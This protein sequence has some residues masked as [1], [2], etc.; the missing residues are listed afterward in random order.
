[1]QKQIAIVGY[2]FRLPG[3]DRAAFWGDLAAARDLVTE[4]PASRWAKEAYYHPRKSEPG[5]SYTFAAGTLG[6]VTGFDAAFFGISPR[7]AEQMDPQQRLLLELAWEAFEHAGIK[8]SSV[9]GSRGAVYIG[10]SGSDYSYRR[11]DDPASFDASTMTG[12]TASIAAN[13]LSYW[14][15][16]RGPS[17]AV[18]TAC[19]SAMVAFHQACQ[20]LRV[21][22]SELAVAGGVSLHLHPMAFIGFSKAS[23]LSPGGRCKVFDAAGDGYVRSEG[24]GIFLLKTLDAALADGDRV[25]AVVAGSGVNCDGKT[26]GLTVPSW[27]RQ[28]ELLREVYAEAGIRPGD[29]DYLEAHGT[30]TAVGDPIETRALGAALGEARPA[31][32]PLLIG[33]VKSNVGH[34]E[35]ASA[36]AGLVK[37]LACLQQRAVPPTVHLK[38]LNPNIKQ[39]AWNLRVVTKTTPLDSAKPLVIGVNS[40]GFGGANAHVILQSAERLQPEPARPETPVAAP[41]VPLLLSGRG[42]PALRAAA[43]QYA[44]L[45]QGASDDQYYDIAF[46]AYAH[47]EL[48]EQ[49]AVVFGLEREAAAAALERFAGGERSPDLFEGEALASASRAVFVYSGNGSQWAGMGRTLLAE[50][51]EFAAVLAGLDALFA[52]HGQ[53]ALLEQLQRDDLAEALAATEVAQPLLFAIQVGVTELLRQLGLAPAAVV[54]HSVGEVAAAWACGALTLDQAVQVILE[55][56]AQQGRTR[57]EGG[58]LAVGLGEA[59]LRELLAALPEAG[60]LTIAGVNSPRGVTVAGAAS[61][62]DRLESL[63]NEREVFFRRLALDYAFH[64]AAMDPL[65]VPLE[66]ALSGLRPEAGRLPF[67]STVTGGRLGGERLD[68]HYWWR[69]IREPVQF[70]GAVDALVRD[71][72]NVLVEVGPHAVL[73]NYVNEGLRNAGVSGRVIPTLARDDDALR[74]V[75]EAFCQALLAG[76][77]VDLARLFPVR[78]RLVELPAYPWQREPFWLAATA[79]G[80]DLINRRKQHPLL[81]YR[82]RENAA[83][84]ENHIDAALYP[85][86]GDHAVGDTVVFPAAGYAELALAAAAAWRPADSC[87]LEELE[88]RAPLLLE[89]DASKTVRFSIDESDG[90][91]RITSRDRLSGDP[92]LLNAEGRILGAAAT[93]PLGVPRQLPA[94]PVEATAAE[95]YALTERVGLG[96]GPAFRAVAAVW[97]CENQVVARLRQPADGSGFAASRLDPAA[98]DGAFQLLV[99]L[100]AEQIEEHGGVAFVPVKIG[101]L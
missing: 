23:M 68:A 57:G 35:A 95:H 70:A 74:R 34:L 19:S 65:Q 32:R 7:E 14:F 94:R 79:E 27:E 61:A 29:I 33:S 89:G 62:L 21:G 43:R 63:L 44:A 8:P 80:Y 71:G 54:G 98:L 69:N 46:S 55:R 76:A 100:F 81:G 12:N 51:P 67:Y 25:Y 93:P 52:K 75:H 49:R 101:R 99:D 15:D 60:E 5:S 4:V 10:F 17:M 2:A 1:M 40:F 56:S 11:A 45:L 97:R 22:E 85:A 83:Q 30:G 78:G 90:R 9:R 59:A 6:D 3:T 37:A 47:R 82:L 86:L 91:F 87:E 26:N 53:F 77:P 13:R 18:D 16:L 20:S 42:A 39:D 58:M 48:H 36:V 92:W 38:R 24:A 96:Y 72:F 64:S 73:R 50:S 84:W 28:A 88:I 66:Q 41:R 31:G